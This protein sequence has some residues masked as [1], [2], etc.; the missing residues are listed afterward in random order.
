[1]CFASSSCHSA[2]SDRLQKASC[3][4][5]LRTSS[6]RQFRDGAVCTLQVLWVMP[7]DEASHERN[8]SHEPKSVQKLGLE[9]VKADGAPKA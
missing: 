6:F 8:P 5:G 7:A 4:C 9:A 1:M 2:F 3:F